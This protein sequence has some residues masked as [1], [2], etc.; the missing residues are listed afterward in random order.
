MVCGIA[1]YA[2]QQAAALRREGH[3]VDI[4]SPREG[5]GDFREDLL[6]GLRPL[7]LLK[8]LWAYDEL[9]IHFTPYF[10]YKTDS[11][12]NRLLTSVA[13][14]LVM[15][16][17]GQRVTFLIHETS[18][19]ID[20][21]TRGRFRHRVDRWYWRLARRVVF[22]SR[23]ERDLFAR[24]YRLDP[25]RPQFEVWA[26]EKFMVRRCALDREGARDA[27]G[28]RHDKLLLLCIG[29]IQPHKGFERA[30]EALRQVP[31]PRLVLRIVGSV[32]LAWDLAHAYAQRL[33]DLADR[34]PRCQV[35][36]GYLS[37]ELFDTWI[38]AADYLII[39]YHEIWTSGVA[40]RAKLYG[41]PLLAANTGGLAEQLTE[42]SH[43][44]S[45][46]AELSSLIQQIAEHF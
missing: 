29:F 32:R 13:F 41:R 28:L 6:G 21:P 10:F 7:R 38:A 11:A 45:S 27:L 1:N 35:I 22:H 40:A 30:I 44:F 42:G 2:E 26:H 3:R 20:Q 46:D 5:E 17:A 8:Y 9:V 34:D 14:V 33:H 18:F 12:F 4:L 31:D 36:E 39:P 43:L 15:I 24:F 37:D 19:K 25:D 16:L 23:R